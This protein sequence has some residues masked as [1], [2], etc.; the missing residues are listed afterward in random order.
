MP[1][2]ILHKGKIGIPA[3]D[4]VFR[5]K[6]IEENAA[7]ATRFFAM[8][9][10]EVFVAPFLVALVV[11][12]GVA[13]TGNLHRLVKHD[14]VGVFL[15]ASAVQNGCEV[16]AAAEPLGGSDDHPGIHV[17]GWNMRIYRMGNQRNAAGPKPR[18]EF[19]TGDLLAKLR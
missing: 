19:S 8:L 5:A 11:S 12:N 3:A 7:D 18:I 6:P 13:C 15:S 10:I 9:E 4:G 1:G 14:R 16:C 2:H 17:N